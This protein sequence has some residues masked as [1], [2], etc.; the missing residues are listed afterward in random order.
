MHMETA[1]ESGEGSDAPLH[2]MNV[3]CAALSLLSQQNVQLVHRAEPPECPPLCGPGDPQPP[4]GASADLPPPP[5][6]GAGRH[7]TDASLAR[8]AGRAGRRSADGPADADPRTITEPLGPVLAAI[9]KELNAVLY[10]DADPNLILQ[11]PQTQQVEHADRLISRMP[12]PSLDKPLGQGTH[13]LPGRA[14]GGAL[15]V[16]TVTR[17][18]S[19][20]GPCVCPSY[21]SNALATA[22][23]LCCLTLRRTI[24]TGAQRCVAIVGRANFGFHSCHKLTHALVPLSHGAGTRRGKKLNRPS[25]G[26]NGQ[27]V[28]LHP[29][30]PQCAVSL[31]HLC[32]ALINGI[33]LLCQLFVNTP[34][35]FSRL[36]PGNSMW[37]GMMAARFPP[38]AC[39]GHCLGRTPHPRRVG[40]RPKNSLRTYNRPQ[41]SGP[42]DKLHFFV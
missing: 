20:Q 2:R 22:K 31:L 35:G 12:R 4:T 11:A 38:C 41:I 23:P 13:R 37:K 29:P 6:D 8:G 10:V 17:D 36:A 16:F 34:K 40:H 26:T 25:L 9:Y 15:H 14:R 18:V 39:T 42:F 30:P 1:M 5:F 3:A 19:S 33:V 24:G 32:S 28:K 27:P 21:E 7:S